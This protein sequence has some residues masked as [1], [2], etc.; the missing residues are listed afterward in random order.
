MRGDRWVYF[1]FPSREGTEGCVS[2]QRKIYASDLIG[3]YSVILGLD[4]GIQFAK[5]QT[6]RTVVLPREAARRVNGRSR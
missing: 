3:F 5:H 6:A 4:P 1:F 2:S